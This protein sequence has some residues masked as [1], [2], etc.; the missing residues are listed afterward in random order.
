[1]FKKPFYF[2]E[3]VKVW[4]WGLGQG[5]NWDMH[6]RPAVYMLVI[7]SCL[8]QLPLNYKRAMHKDVNYRKAFD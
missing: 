2:F 7:F 4:D 8:N 3:G 5:K 6:Y 1:M